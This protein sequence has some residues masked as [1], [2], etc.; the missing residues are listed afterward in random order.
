M[1]H[2]A[3]SLC[4]LSGEGAFTLLFIL[5]PFTYVDVIVR[6]MQSSDQNN[7]IYTD[8]TSVSYNAKNVDPCKGEKMVGQ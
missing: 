2:L 4:C 8:M 3:V 5:E 1:S 7:M 6:P